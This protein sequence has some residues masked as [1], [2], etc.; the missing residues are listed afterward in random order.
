MA[1]GGHHDTRKEGGWLVGLST[2]PCFCFCFIL[3]EPSVYTG[4]MS[5]WYLLCLFTLGQSLAFV[6]SCFYIPY[7]PFYYLAVFTLV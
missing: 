2:E 1:E 5:Y 7:F 4:R 6:F 3:K